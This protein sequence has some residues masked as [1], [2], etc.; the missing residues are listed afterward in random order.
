MIL[1]VQFHFPALPAFLLN[2]CCGF[3]SCLCM[4]V[5]FMAASPL[6]LRRLYDTHCL[7]PDACTHTGPVRVSAFHL[8]G[9]E[10]YRL[11]YRVYTKEWCGF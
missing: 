10:Y 4:F 3:I 11:T 8:N 2:I 9:S 1:S 7:T 5:N 6:I